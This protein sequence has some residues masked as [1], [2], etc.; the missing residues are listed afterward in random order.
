M[1]DNLTDEQ[2]ADLNLSDAQIAEMSFSGL[3]DLISRVRASVASVQ[4]VLSFSNGM[5]RAAGQPQISMRADDALH[6]EMAEQTA[7]RLLV[8]L[9]RRWA[10]RLSAAF[11]AT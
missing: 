7:K 3:I 1:T 9:E 5:L 10:R 11:S 6:I 2:I 8:E 4:A